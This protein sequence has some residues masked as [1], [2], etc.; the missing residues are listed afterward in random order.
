MI[1]PSAEGDDEKSGD[2]AHHAGR[3]VELVNTVLPQDPTTRDDEAIREEL[4]TGHGRDHE[5]SSEDCDQNSCPHETCLA[6][7]HLTGTVCQKTVTFDSGWRSNLCHEKVAHSRP[8]GKAV[9]SEVDVSASESVDSLRGPI[10]DD[11]ITGIQILVM[12]EDES[13]VGR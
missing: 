11:E 3:H 9:G 7:D 1:T 10:V 4:R 8:I 13:L 12:A 6:T 5:K 2:D